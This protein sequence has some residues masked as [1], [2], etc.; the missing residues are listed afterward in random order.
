MDS[1]RIASRVDYVMFEL[2]AQPGLSAFLEKANKQRVCRN[3]ISTSDNRYKVTTRT[4]ERMRTREAGKQCES[5]RVHLPEILKGQNSGSTWEPLTRVWAENSRKRS[6]LTTAVG[7]CVP[8]LGE[9]SRKQEDVDEKW[10]TFGLNGFANLMW[11]S[12]SRSWSP[13]SPPGSVKIGVPHIW[14]FQNA[15]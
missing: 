2:W 9:T 11:E 3:M 5:N 12:L 10:I 1:R 7:T 13:R 4:S 14:V 8:C 6:R 15:I